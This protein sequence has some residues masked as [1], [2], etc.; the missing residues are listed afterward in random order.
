MR[1]GE[2]KGT[3]ELFS[4]QN[5]KVG[6]AGGKRGSRKKLRLR[7]CSC[8]APTGGSHNV[9][10]IDWGQSRWKQRHIHTACPVDYAYIYITRTSAGSGRGRRK[11]GATSSMRSVTYHMT[12][13]IVAQPRPPG[14]YASMANIT[15]VRRYQIDKKRNKTPSFALNAAVDPAIA[16]MVLFRFARGEGSSLLRNRRTHTQPTCW[17]SD[18]EHRRSP[19]T[20]YEHPPVALQR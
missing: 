11:K 13:S 15:D 14:M 5:L 7:P 9:R 10:G 19:T 16:V 12:Y 18:G 3:A 6:T 1:R 8:A 2:R 4:R 17:R 20:L